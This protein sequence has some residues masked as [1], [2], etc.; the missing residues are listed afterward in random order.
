MQLTFVTHWMITIGVGFA[1]LLW[2]WILMWLDRRD[3]RKRSR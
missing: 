1:L 3:V 2:G